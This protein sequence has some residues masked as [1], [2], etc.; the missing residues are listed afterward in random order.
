MRLAPNLRKC[1]S[2]E[3]H[4]KA[5]SQEFEGY[6]ED[7]FEEF[8]EDHGDEDHAPASSSHESHCTNEGRKKESRPRETHQ[9]KRLKTRGE[10]SERKVKDYE[11]M[12]AT[13]Q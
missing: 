5:S 9:R 7:T 4:A 3:S 11:I 6:E 12:K 10:E 2:N 13:R 1:G 8:H